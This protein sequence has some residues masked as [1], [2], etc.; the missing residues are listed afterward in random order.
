MRPEPRPADAGAARR[1]PEPR[2]ADAGA[3]RCVPEPRPADA[4][5]ADVRKPRP[6]DAGAAQR[7]QR[8]WPTL[9]AA[10]DSPLR[11]GATRRAWAFF[12]AWAA[13]TFEGAAHAPKKARKR[14]AAPG[15][16]A[17]SPPR[18]PRVHLRSSLSPMARQRRASTTSIPTNDY[19]MARQRRASA[20]RTGHPTGGQL[21]SSTACSAGADR[22]LRAWGERER[23][24]PRLA[25]C[26]PP[27]PN[28]PAPPWQ[29][30]R[31]RPQTAGASW[32]C[33]R[34]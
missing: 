1:V 8:S 30:R 20:G 29:A 18:A 7:I 32:A 15:R 10:A 12:G 4:G 13:I 14:L 6:A 5:A 9:R 23:R 25:T 2:P 26:P 27:P 3:A 22:D 33:T 16:D 21:S 28:R 31:R 17:S 24:A 34:P 19:P 11:P